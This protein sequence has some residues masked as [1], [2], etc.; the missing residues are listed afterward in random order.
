M[1]RTLILAVIASLVNGHGRVN[2][3]RARNGYADSL[4][5]G[6]PWTVF[7]DGK[8]QHGIC[9]NA[10]GAPQTYNAVGEVQGQYK[11]G[12]VAEITV[13]LTAHH[14]GF[15]EF[16]VCSD[17]GQL[18]E[19]CFMKHRL[20]KEG[21]ECNCGSDT[22]LSCAECN[23]CRRWWKPLLEGELAQSVT[24]G[25]VG[26]VLEG[27]G[28]LVEYEYTLRYVIPSNV[29]SSHAV[30]RWH[31]LTTQAC[32]S[33]TSRPEE[34][35]NCVDIAISDSIDENDFGPSVPYDNE[36]LE[37]LPVTD[38]RPLIDS[39][40]LRGL[41]VDCP[42]NATIGTADDYEGACGAKVDG[43]YE[44]CKK[45]QGFDAVLY[46]CTNPPPSG[47]LCDSEC[48]K[49]WWKCGEGELKEV[50]YIE[51]VPFGTRCKGNEFVHEAECGDAACGSCS[52]CL[53]SIGLC[54]IFR[55]RDLCIQEVGNVW[56]GTTHS[57]NFIGE[58]ASPEKLKNI[59]PHVETDTVHFMQT[60]NNGSTGMLSREL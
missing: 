48:S 14:V 45:V 26:P 33:P 57:T 22:T 43:A 60:P 8:Y 1:I 51:E 49:F 17:A 20:L 54:D 58:V 53:V 16:E 11:A 31:Y 56:C 6:G 10:P 52:H 2:L 37:A 40:E 41:Y 34:F 28:T 24:E 47:K 21:C 19:E 3:P 39:Q 30:L 59:H 50:A 35:W 27:R 38:L 44:N 46:D 32:T 36:A 12:N 7:E 29:K 4:F 15:F 13:A 9:G 55:D 5:A 23:K 42:A 18:S 25:Y